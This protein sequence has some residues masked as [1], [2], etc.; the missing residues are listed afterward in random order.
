MSGGFGYELD[1]NNLTPKDKKEIKAYN[2]IAKAFR[3][4]IIRKYYELTL[5]SAKDKRRTHY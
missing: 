2:E 3:S 1:V 5:S 4:V